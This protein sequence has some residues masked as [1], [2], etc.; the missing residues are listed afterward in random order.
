M[1]GTNVKIARIFNTYGPHMRPDDGRVISNFINAILDETEIIIYGNG[2]QTR[3]LCFVTDMVDGLIA[4]M[5]S[6]C[7]RSN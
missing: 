7:I 2:E 5:N 4:L 3:S 6:E 1:Y